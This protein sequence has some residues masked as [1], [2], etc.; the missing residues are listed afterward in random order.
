MARAMAALTIAAGIDDG[1]SRRSKSR[2]RV[3]SV[4]SV[5]KYPSLTWLK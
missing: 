5:A 4:R 3:I 2:P 1:A